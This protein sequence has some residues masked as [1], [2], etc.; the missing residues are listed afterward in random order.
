VLDPDDLTDAFIRARDAAGCEGV[1]LHDLRHAWA[2]SMIYSTGSVAAVSKSLGHSSTHF[3]SDV[4]VHLS[5]E[6][7]AQVAAAADEALAKAVGE[8]I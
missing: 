1:R 4:Y 3:T 2:T 5:A 7:G 6:A 8:A